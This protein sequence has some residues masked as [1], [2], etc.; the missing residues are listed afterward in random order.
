[1]II[2]RIIKKIVRSLGITFFWVFEVLGL[3]GIPD[4]PPE[5]GGNE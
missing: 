4:S 1:M 3:P 5:E 2:L